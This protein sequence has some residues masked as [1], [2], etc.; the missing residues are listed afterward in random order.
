MIECESTAM[1]QIKNEFN[2]NIDNNNNEVLCSN[3]EFNNLH[4]KV[5]FADCYWDKK[6]SKILILE[7]YTQKVKFDQ[8]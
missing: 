3:L 4:Y 6:P 5:K 2:S 8:I 7:D 1:I